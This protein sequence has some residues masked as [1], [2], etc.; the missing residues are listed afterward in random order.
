MSENKPVLVEWESKSINVQNYYYY[1]NI[2]IIPFFYHQK[3]KK[4]EL[5]QELAQC[6]T[7][8]MPIY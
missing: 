3:R 8:F 4:E 5:T 2:I 7:P 1:N 6:M